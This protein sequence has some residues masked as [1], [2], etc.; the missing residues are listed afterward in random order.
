[1]STYINMN[2]PNHKKNDLTGYPQI[3]KDYLIYLETIRALST[4]TVNGYAI[5]LRT[6]FRF[7]LIN[8]QSVSSDIPFDQ[9]DISG[10]DVAFVR[11]ITKSDIYS[12][13]YYVTSDRDNAAATR[14][15]K[16]SSIKGFYKFCTKKV[17]LLT[18]DPCNDI[19]VPTQKKRLPKYLTLR[20]SQELLENVQSDF[21]SRDYC[22]L[23][24]FLNCGMRLSELVGL[25]MRDLGEETVRIIGKGNKERQ[26]YLN[27]ACFDAL[28]DYCA[29]RNGLKTIVDKEALFVSKKTGKR[30][31]PRRVQ[32]IVEARLAAAGLGGKGF[33]T[34]KL[35]HTA[36]TLMHQYGNVDMLTLKEILGHEHVSTTEIYTHL[37]Q[38]ELRDA[39]MANPLSHQKSNAPQKIRK[40]DFLDLEDPPEMAETEE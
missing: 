15:R 35:R 6:F 23:T 21:T 19:D 9:I 11:K 20:E 37:S 28:R 2:D 17:N 7:I 26:V 22:M 18:E 38:K 32:Q 4:R 39:T 25:N 12:F 13:L 30:L 40:K 10:I 24:L 5:D 29:E 36:A 33:S 34:H 27:Q 16:L 1:M 8:N 3:M 14:A 31:T